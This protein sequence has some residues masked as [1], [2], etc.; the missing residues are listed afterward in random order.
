MAMAKVLLLGGTADGRKMA[1]ELHSHNVDVTYSVAGLVRTPDVPCKILSGGFKERGGLKHYIQSHGITAILD[2]TH[3]YAV[4][5]TSRAWQACREIGIPY[6]RFQ[7]PLWQQ[8]EGDHWIQ[9]ASLMG[10]FDEMQQYNRIMIGVG[11]LDEEHMN[12]IAQYDNQFQLYRTAAKPQT[13]IPNTM[14]W[15]KAIGP[16]EY[17]QELA[18]LREHKIEAVI[19]K[20]SGG[21]ATY[22][23]IAAA[24]T[25][26]IPVFMLQRPALPEAITPL[27]N[28]EDCKEVL[29][30]YLS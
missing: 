2:M 28:I 16:F 13:D 14:L 8:Q 23:K 12:R 15:L 5:I 29:Q 25:L 27:Y 19:S 18:L 20:N 10:L 21:D 4:N 30:R 9:G 3:P 11:Q 26:G 17:E 7:R 1:S 24:R 6:L 22:A